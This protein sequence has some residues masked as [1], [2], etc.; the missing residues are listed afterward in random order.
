MS[1]R[2]RVANHRQGVGSSNIRVNRGDTTKS[3]CPSPGSYRRLL[4][5]LL[6]APAAGRFCSAGRTGVNQ[7]RIRIIRGTRVNPRLSGQRGA[8]ILTV[9]LFLC[10]R[11]PERL[12]RPG[13]FDWS[14]L[15]PSSAFLK[16]SVGLAPA[17]RAA[18]KC[19]P[20][21][22]AARRAGCTAG[23]P[24]LGVWAAEEAESR[25]G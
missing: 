5:S 16:R 15:G 6:C 8:R 14:S 10:D 7:D 17:S 13:R 25:W 9:D 24:G 20:G 12:R 3:P 19:G 23:S 11:P 22:R 4:V 18:R 21:A 2:A 1:G